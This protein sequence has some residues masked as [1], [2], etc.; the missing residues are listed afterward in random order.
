VV[1]AKKMRNG[2]T[3]DSYPHQNVSVAPIR[4]TI[5]A[6]VIVYPSSAVIHAT[7][8]HRGENAI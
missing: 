4:S 5:N 8:N 2:L 7:T 1:L 6:E 3:E